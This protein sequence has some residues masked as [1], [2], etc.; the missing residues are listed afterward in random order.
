MKQPVDIS[1]VSRNRQRGIS[2]MEVLI[3]ILVLA[4]GL[5][6]LASLQMTSLKQNNQ[7]L[8]RSLATLMAYDLSDRMRANPLAITDGW[9][10]S[11]TAEANA[12]CNTTTGCTPMDMVKNDFFDWNQALANVL[13]NGQGFVC[14]DSTPDADVVPADGPDCDGSGNLYTIY[15]TWTETQTAA[16]QVRTFSTSFQP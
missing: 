4:I 15:I 14:I 2:M 16:E 12:N 1:V 9:Y 10:D 13:P 3:T 11:P 5:L 7:S 8:Q 6:G